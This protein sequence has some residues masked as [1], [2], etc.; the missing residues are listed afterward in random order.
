MFHVSPERPMCVRNVFYSNLPSFVMDGHTKFCSNNVNRVS[1]ETHVNV[2]LIGIGYSR[3]L[4][5]QWQSTTSPLDKAIVNHNPLAVGI[6]PALNDF[7][8][9]DEITNKLTEYSTSVKR[10][11]LRGLLLEDMF[12]PCRVHTVTLCMD[13]IR[14][15]INGSPYELNCNVCSRDFVMKLLS[16]GWKLDQICIDH[17]RMFNEYVANNFGQHFF[18]FERYST[19]KYFAR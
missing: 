2:L 4:L 13:S 14:D 5:E 17:Y 6:I 9:L 3:E 16:K 12:H 19:R 10:D 7:L 11:F 18:K 15:S 1:N 8:H